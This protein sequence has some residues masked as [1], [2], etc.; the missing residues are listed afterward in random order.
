MAEPFS[1]GCV[2][3]TKKSPLFEI[4]P[5]GSAVHNPSL[6][7]TNPPVRWASPCEPFRYPSRQFGKDARATGLRLGRG[8][9]LDGGL[10][11]RAPDA[12]P[13]FD[14]IGAVDLP[15][16]AGETP[17]EQSNVASTKTAIFTTV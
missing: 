13:A 3:V 14:A 7:C 12:V 8:E 17:H 16:D 5:L 10:S 2:S 15:F 4:P 6:P 9:A 11:I 1:V